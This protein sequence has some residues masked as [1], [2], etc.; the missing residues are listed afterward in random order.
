[1]RIPT[2][3]LKDT[4][5]SDSTSSDPTNPSAMIIASGNN[6]L[7]TRGYP[8]LPIAPESSVAAGS[9][10]RTSLFFL[11]WDPQFKGFQ[12]LINISKS[13]LATTREWSAHDLLR[14]AARYIEKRPLQDIKTFMMA[15]EGSLAAKDAH[16][17]C[18]NATTLILDPNP[19][20][21]YC[22]ET[23]DYLVGPQLVTN[24]AAGDRPEP[25]PTQDDVPT[26]VRPYWLALRTLVLQPD[27]NTLCAMSLEKVYSYLLAREEMCAFESK[28]LLLFTVDNIQANALKA[29]NKLQRRV[30]QLA[31]TLHIHSARLIDEG[32]TDG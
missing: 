20:R 18:P 27:V 21:Y 10:G 22:G 31:I 12:L 30:P 15:A 5:A 4:A 14:S 1:M 24:T 7:S 9:S 16:L 26:V 13:H 23:L 25:Q 17:I 6:D 19:S 2:V 29:L 11:M 28:K 8:R 32:L 3:K